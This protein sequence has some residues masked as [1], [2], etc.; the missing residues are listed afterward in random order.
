MCVFS[1]FPVC[2][3]SSN[4]ILPRPVG[5]NIFLHIQVSQMYVSSCVFPQIPR[6]LYSMVYSMS[7]FWC[8]KGNP[9]LAYLNQ[10]FWFPSSNP[11]TPPAKLP[12]LSKKCP[13]H[14]LAKN[15][16]LRLDSSHFLSPIQFIKKSSALLPKATG[17]EPPGP[18]H[19]PLSPSSMAKTKSTGPPIVSMTQ[20]SSQYG[21]STAQLAL[22]TLP[23][24]APVAPTASG[25]RT[26]CWRMAS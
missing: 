12:H 20:Q 8:L 5:L 4:V 3:F 11:H 7:L 26:R 2:L 15:L 18:N 23:H 17:G 13:L 24:T 14:P 22:P 10:I 21:L 25:V 16:W 9:V 6:C 19:Y 1:T